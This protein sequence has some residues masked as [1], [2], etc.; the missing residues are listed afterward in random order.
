M[1]NTKRNLLKRRRKELSLTQLDIIYYL[2]KN[3]NIKITQ[4]Y[5]SQI[6]RGMRS[7]NLELAK[8]ISKILDSSINDLF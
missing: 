4:G 5:Y 6:E 7:P 3:Y 1:Q 2:D 8:S